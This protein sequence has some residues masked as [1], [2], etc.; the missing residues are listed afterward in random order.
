MLAL[1]EFLLTA[2]NKD[3][4]SRANRFH[5]RCHAHTYKMKQLKDVAPAMIEEWSVTKRAPK[6]AAWLHEQD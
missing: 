4:I 5:R 2:I 6:H 1:I 3:T